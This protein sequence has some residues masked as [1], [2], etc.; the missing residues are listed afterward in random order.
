MSD[1]SEAPTKDP[2]AARTVEEPLGIRCGVGARASLEAKATVVM[3]AATTRRK[4][5]SDMSEAPTKDPTA[6]EAP[7]V[8]SAGAGAGART[9]LDATAMVDMVAATMRT[10]KEI[11]FIMSMVASK[12]VNGGRTARRLRGRG[13]R[14]DGITGGL[15]AKLRRRLNKPPT[16]IRTSVEGRSMRWREVAT[17][18]EKRRD[19]DG[20]G[21]GIERWLD[22]GRD[23]VVTGRWQRLGFHSLYLLFFNSSYTLSQPRAILTRHNIYPINFS[24]EEHG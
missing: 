5:T 9:S 15:E 23:G 21:F 13:K 18:L 2:T 1:K 22:L 10:V 19:G 7:L 3:V 16:R 4:A 14:L 8:A 11:F 12:L 24:I 6:A 17:G 20:V